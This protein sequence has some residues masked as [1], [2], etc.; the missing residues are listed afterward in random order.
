MVSVSKNI[1]WAYYST[2]HQEVCN[3]LYLWS[4]ATR[5]LHCSRLRRSLRSHV[6][7]RFLRLEPQARAVFIVARPR[8]D[9]G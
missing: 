3:I 9:G 6:R 8:C 2:P 5:F 4:L 7:W 1:D